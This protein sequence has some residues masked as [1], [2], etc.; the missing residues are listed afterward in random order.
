MPSRAVILLALIAGSGASRALAHHSFAA[1]FDYDL[2]GRIEGVVVEVLYVNPHAR[3]FLEVTDESGE[4]VL[5]D[6]QSRSPSALQ[7][8]GWTSDTITLGETVA[9]E[10]NL[11]LNNTRKIWLQE[12]TLSSG[13]RIRADGQEPSAVAAE[14]ED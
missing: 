6:V 14:S 2:T 3:Y 12:V 11:G 1:E 13:E 10:G 5:W 4:T 9:I 7:R 8:I